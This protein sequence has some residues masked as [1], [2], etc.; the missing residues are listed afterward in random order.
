MGIEPRNLLTVWQQTA[1][2]DS[3]IQLYCYDCYKLGYDVMLSVGLLQ[4][5]NRNVVVSKTRAQHINFLFFLLGCPLGLGP[6]TKG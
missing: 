3:K 2:P 5:T 4:I 6:I 1:T